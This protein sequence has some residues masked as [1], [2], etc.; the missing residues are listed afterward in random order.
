MLMLST[1][2]FAGEAPTRAAIRKAIEAARSSLVEV[3]GPH[4]RGPGVIVGARGEVLTSVDYLALEQ[5][6]VV[7]GGEQKSASVKLAD[8]AS[9]VGMV[10][11]EGDGPFQ[12]AVVNALPS[13]RAGDWLMGFRVRGGTS[14]PQTGKV[15]SA[16]SQRRPFL[17]TTLLLAPGSPIYDERGRLR[18]IAVRGRGRALPVAAVKVQLAAAGSSP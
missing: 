3:I 9:G 13:F 4:H 10:D 18:A 17:T 16:L 1:S 8:A 6:Q 12:A 5:A 15:L 11:I 7:V 2:V 14:E